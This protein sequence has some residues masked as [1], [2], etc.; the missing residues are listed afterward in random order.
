MHLTKAEESCVQSEPRV[1]EELLLERML[2]FAEEA[3]A[4]SS[5]ACSQWGLGTPRA[6]AG[7]GRGVKQMRGNACEAVSDSAVLP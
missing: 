3:S 5:G 6:V 2:Q 1:A 4:L 7:E